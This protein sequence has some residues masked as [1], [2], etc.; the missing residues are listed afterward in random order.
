MLYKRRSQV[1]RISVVLIAVLLVFSVVLS[2]CA[3]PA[4][5][6]KIATDATFNPFEYTDENG[7]LIGFDIDLMNEIAKKA[8]FTFE[9]VNV[10]FDSVLAGL[11][12]CQYDAA[13]AAISIT[14]ERQASM[15]FSQPYLDAGL[16]VVVNKTNTDIKSLADLKGKTVAAQ[17]GTTGEI[18]AKKIEGVNYKPYD[19]YELAFLEL[20]NKGVDAVIADNPVAMGYVAANPEKIMAVGDV[21]NNDQY[22]IAIC[23]TNTDLQA[24]IDKALKE[25][26]DSG[27]IKELAKTYIK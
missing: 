13:I 11:S 7:K 20:A 9:W 15:I 23:K 16:I 18:E 24:K 14:P 19:S 5:A 8:G 10:P 12:E 2:A 1:K 27:F 3:K 26:T 22:G 21:F 17:L 6:I 25:L 4:P